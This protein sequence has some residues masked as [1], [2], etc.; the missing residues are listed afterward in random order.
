MKKIIL[1]I[2]TFFIFLNVN[3]SDD[4]ICTMDALECSDWTWVWRTWP[5]CEFVCPWDNSQKACTR[6]YAPVCAE[7]QVQ[8]FA[9]PCYPIK[10]TFSNK[11]E[12]ENNSLATF[13]HEWT[14]ES[15]SWTITQIANPASTYCEENWWKIS[16]SE[17][18][19][20]SQYGICY[21]DDNRQCEEWSLYR[22]ECTVWWRKITWYI[23]EYAKYCAITWNEFVNKW[24][25]ANWDD[26]W[27]CK[28]LSWETID[29]KTYYFSWVTDQEESFACPMIYL[30]VCG[31]DGET[32]WNSCMAQK[33]WV[34]YEWNCIWE[35]LETKVYDAWKKAVDK[36]LSKLSVE[37][38]SSILEKVIYRAEK[39]A[40]KY[41][42]ESVKSWLY[43]FIASLAWDTLHESIYEK[44]IKNNISSITSLKPTLWWKWYV[45]KIIWLDTNIAKVEYEDG[46]VVEKI[47]VQIKVV[48]GKIK[49][50]N[51][52]KTLEINTK[53]DNKDFSIKLKVP[54]SWEG[55]YEYKFLNDWVLQFSF[56]SV[57]EW[58]NMLFNLNLHNSSNWQKQVEEWLFNINELQR[59]WSYVISY[60]NSLD[61]PYTKD[62]N[63][64]KYSSMIWDVNEV[65]ESVEVSIK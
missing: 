44:Y 50:T 29:A 18:T 2:F 45:T 59:V 43:K 41:D 31:N 56:K 4:V 17:K 16:I 49:V 14:C 5:N 9:A 65:L 1:F 52:E 53:Y 33:V 62:E 32:Y 13:L 57:W 24:Q 20:W 58:N 15:S 55:N 42:F 51:L 40:S 28:L 12:M 47:K 10:E 27:D 8:C 64:N 37:K 35:K 34:K 3:A 26:I 46:H 48:N 38:T 61:M 23:W 36:N 6:E 7:V 11:C 63:I 21:F 30:P 60:S 22:W 54:T 39:L 19:D 25:D